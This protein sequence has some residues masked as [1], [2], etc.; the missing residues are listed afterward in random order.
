M[1][2]TPTRSDVNFLRCLHRLHHL[3]GEST[4][5]PRLAQLQE[6]CSFSLAPTAP[7]SPTWAIN[8]SLRFAGLHMGNLKFIL[9]L[10][11]PTRIRGQTTQ[12]GASHNYIQSIVFLWRLQRQ[13][14][15]PNRNTHFVIC[16]HYLSFICGLL[17]SEFY[18]GG[19]FPCSNRR[20][21]MAGAPSP[22]LASTVKT[23][24]PLCLDSHPPLWAGDQY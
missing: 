2:R 18:C 11:R 6:W 15:Q 20:S 16:V 24:R 8:F 1:L 4:F 7:A 5:Y 10:R 9:R 17:S 23:Y 12:F 3:S 22:L 19:P 13:Q 14:A 21:E